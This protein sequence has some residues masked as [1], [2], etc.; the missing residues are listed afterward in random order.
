MP[1]YIILGS[2]TQEGVKEVGKTEEKVK[3]AYDVAKEYQ[4]EI[5]QLFYTFGQYDFVG[6]AEFP[7]NQAMMKALLRI[8]RTGEVRTETLVAMPVDEYVNLTKELA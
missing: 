1:I 2:Y 7:D 5:K 4:G 8:A 3:G 6:I